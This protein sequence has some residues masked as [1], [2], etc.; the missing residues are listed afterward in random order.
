MDGVLNAVLRVSEGT[1]AL[2]PSD[3][4]APQKWAYLEGIVNRGRYV[5]HSSR[6]RGASAFPDERVRERNP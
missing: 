2:L 5:V 1:G 4:E 3:S 6:T